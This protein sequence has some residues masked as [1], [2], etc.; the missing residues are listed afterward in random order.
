MDKLTTNWSCG[1][2]RIIRYI[3][4]VI[5]LTSEYNKTE[6]IVMPGS[7]EASVKYTAV[8]PS[9]CMDEL[10]SL[11]EKKVIPSVNQG[12][13]LAVEDFVLFHKQRAYKL[14]MQEAAADKDF[15]RRT[16]EAQKAF[17]EVDAEGL[18]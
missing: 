9:M 8:L 14:A 7:R 12:I 16:L 5:L 11:A 3:L 1:Y 4:I 15:I 17:S 2:R 18:V 13:R 6:V 10:K